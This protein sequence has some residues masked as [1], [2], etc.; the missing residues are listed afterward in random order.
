MIINLKIKNKEIQNQKVLL[1]ED[2]KRQN[3]EIENLN[4]KINY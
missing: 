3:D 4:Q 2:L 1:K